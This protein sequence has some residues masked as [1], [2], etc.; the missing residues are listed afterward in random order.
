M[1]IIGNLFFSGVPSNPRTSLD[2]MKG[3]FEEMPEDSESTKNLS[4]SM[5]KKRMD[6]LQ[7][8]GQMRRYEFSQDSSV[9]KAQI[10]CVFQILRYFIMS[11]NVLFSSKRQQETSAPLSFG[12]L[13]M[14]L[15]LTANDKS[16]E[17]VSTQIF[18]TFW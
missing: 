12:S 13:A 7:S 14:A 17:Q 6:N 8:T 5:L 9:F 2:Y 18:Q 10:S 11:R 1:I 15:F 3:L 4:P 16:N